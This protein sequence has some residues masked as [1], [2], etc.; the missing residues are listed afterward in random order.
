MLLSV[1]RNRVSVKRQKTIFISQ[2]PSTTPETIANTAQPII[3]CTVLVELGIAAPT[4]T[5]EIVGTDEA[6][7]SQSETLGF[8]SGTIQQ[9]LKVFKTVTQLVTTNLS[10]VTLSAK[11]RGRDGSQVKTQAELYSCISC[12]ISYTAQSWPNG[13]DGTTQKGNIKILIP[14]FCN[15]SESRLREGDLVTDLDSSAVFMVKGIAFESGV[16]IN[17]FQ[18][19]YAERR[20]GTS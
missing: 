12:Q 6:G 20:E 10:S 15:S 8:S 14:I 7:S 13:R 17:R 11:Y 2:A 1:A 9:G 3:P 5:V 19:V 16:G 4:A 18:T